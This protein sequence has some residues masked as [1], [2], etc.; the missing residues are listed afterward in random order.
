MISGQ[1]K[2]TLNLFSG[3]QLIKTLGMNYIH[4]VLQPNSIHNLPT[5]PYL[6]A[7]A[8]IRP[9]PSLPWASVFTL[10]PTTHSLYSS[11]SDV[12]TASSHLNPL[13]KILQWLHGSQAG[14]STDVETEF[15]IKDIA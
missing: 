7:L 13:L 10:P 9:P 1:Y 3:R 12:I 2:D 5:S 6:P 14:F 4:L 15:G 8:E 11:W